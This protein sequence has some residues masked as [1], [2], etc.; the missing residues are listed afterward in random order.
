MQRKKSTDVARIPGGDD[1][2]NQIDKASPLVPTVLL[3]DPS[4][5]S[6]STTPESLALAAQ[7]TPAQEEV[8]MAWPAP[9][10]DNMNAADTWGV[11]TIAGLDTNPDDPWGLNNGATAAGA[12]GAEVKGDNPYPG[13]SGGGGLKS[14][15]DRS[16]ARGYGKEGFRRGR[17]LWQPPER[18]CGWEG[19]R[20]R[21]G[22]VCDR[23]IY[24]IHPPGF[25]VL[26]Y[27][28]QISRQSSRPSRLGRRPQRQWP[29]GAFEQR[30]GL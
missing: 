21:G 4:S 27:P 3:S 7:P 9:S 1:A 2:N 15:K 14:D 24:A 16:N 30:Q 17:P 19:F 11:G 8:D 28:L 20:K 12:W 29:P 13:W 22:Y 5:A 23:L 6:Y 18:D 10:N 25:M 26:M